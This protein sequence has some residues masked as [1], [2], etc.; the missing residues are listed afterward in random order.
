MRI[1]ILCLASVIVLA[2]PLCA[3]SYWYSFENSMDGWA[4]DAADAMMLKRFAIP[5]SRLAKLHR[6]ET[7]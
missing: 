4:A 5:Q 2:A 6:R 7:S 3:Q 1:L